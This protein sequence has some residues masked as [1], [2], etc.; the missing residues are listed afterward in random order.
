[1]PLLAFSRLAAASRHGRATRRS[2]RA[3][4]S[5]KTRLSRIRNITKY[6]LQTI[7]E[8][9]LNTIKRNKWFLYA[10]KLWTYRV[11]NF[12]YVNQNY[13]LRTVKLE[14]SHHVHYYKDYLLN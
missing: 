5:V 8:V 6:G 7:S 11:N 14:L 9:K 2:E 1:M 10:E 3:Y 4:V 12:V 13:Y